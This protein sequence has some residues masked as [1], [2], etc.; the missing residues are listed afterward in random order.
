MV[1]IS[2]EIA[3]GF[4]GLDGSSSAQHLSL[5]CVD[6]LVNIQR[7]PLGKLLEAQIALDWKKG[8]KRKFSIHSTV[9]SEKFKFI[10]QGRSP[11]CV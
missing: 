2:R 7:G 6:S 5:T 11:L 3:L 8:T 1:G 9:E 4:G 10:L